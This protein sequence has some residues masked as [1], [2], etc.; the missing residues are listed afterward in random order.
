M[1]TGGILVGR[2]HGDEALPEIFVEITGQI[3][4]S[5]AQHESASLTFTPESWTA[6]AEGLE[7][8]GG[9]TCVG[10]WHSH[11]ACRWCQKCEP[12]KRRKC[13]LSGE[14]FSD[15]DACL[16]RVVFPKAYS[17]ALVISDSEADGVT[18]PLFGWREG[19]IV[20]RGYYITVRRPAFGDTTITQPKGRWSKP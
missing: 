5:H 19:R 16:F 14:F 7:L 18:W 11:P 6:A 2:L 17:L 20:R 12:E 1:E 15:Q 10:F 8:R 4:V 13:R 3:P 9:E